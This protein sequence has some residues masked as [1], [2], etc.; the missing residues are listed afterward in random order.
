MYET[1]QPH[2][3]DP[4]ELARLRSQWR[5]TRRIRVDDALKPEVADA[6][7]EG[8]AEHGFDFF[9]KH[10]SD[11]RCVF[12]R[13]THTFDHPDRFGPI[14]LAA[15]LIQ[16]EIPRLVTAITGQRLHGSGAG[17]SIDYYTR[18]SYLDVHTDRGADRLVAYVIGLTADSWPAEDGGH[19]EFLEADFE[20]VADRVAPGFG[21]LDLFTVYPL[22]RPH[23]VPLLKKPVTR[24]S[25][26]G[27][28]SG[29]LEA[30]H[31]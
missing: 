15:R 9:E 1:L 7:L 16:D 17:F 10:V 20:T 31:A 22:L 30:D 3:A 5:Q 8:A 28:L 13:Q 23:R 14:A 25:I 19:L 11:V 2:L 12:W 4:V 29:S 26:N 6:L 18:G 21:T 27:W 24:V